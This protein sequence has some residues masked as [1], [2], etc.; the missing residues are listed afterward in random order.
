[1]LRGRHANR[2]WCIDDCTSPIIVAWRKPDLGGDNVDSRSSCLVGLS[3]RVD[4]S[5]LGLRFGLS[6]RVGDSGLGLR[7]GLRVQGVDV[8][9]P[10]RVEAKV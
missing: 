2:K 5:G 7:F 6:F 4:D 9:T 10:P 3:F 8:C 1:M